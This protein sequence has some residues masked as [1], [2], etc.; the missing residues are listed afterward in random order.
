MH[1]PNSLQDFKE[2]LLKRY[3]SSSNT[4]DY[5]DV[6]IQDGELSITDGRDDVRDLP[7]LIEK[8]LALLFLKLAWHCAKPVQLWGKHYIVFVLTSYGT[9]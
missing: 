2:D 7:N 9:Y 6:D 1:T 4:D 3:A 5:S 8:K